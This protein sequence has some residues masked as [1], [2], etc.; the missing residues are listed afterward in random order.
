MG[1]WQC[2]QAQPHQVSYQSLHAGC[3][4]IMD[5]PLK[6]TS[7]LTTCLASSCIQRFL[8]QN[9][10]SMLLFPPAVRIWCHYLCVMNFYCFSEFGCETLHHVQLGLLVVTALLNSNSSNDTPKILFFGWKC[11]AWTINQ[12]NRF[13]RPTWEGE[14]ENNRQ[15]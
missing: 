2:G 7:S 12:G 8:N 6:A 13:T 15:G 5:F 3:H 9:P 14:Q 1:V 4:E 11:I 10:M